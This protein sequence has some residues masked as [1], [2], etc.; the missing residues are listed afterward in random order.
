[1]LAM[2][3]LLAGASTALIFGLLHRSL[4]NAWVKYQESLSNEAESRLADMF[5]FVDLSQ[6]WPLLVALAFV[7]GLLGW[8]LLDSVAFS[9][10]VSVLVL[11]VPRLLLA[12][13]HAARKY[14]LDRQLPDALRILAAALSSGSSLSTALNVMAKDLNPPLS[15]ELSLILREQR[16]GIPL[17]SAL[18][19]F[20]LRIRSES[21]AQA[22]T[23]LRVG[24]ES[25]G[26]LALLLDKLSLN[27]SEQ[28]YMGLKV[29][30]LTT[31]G[32]MQAWVIGVLPLILLGV[33]CALDPNAMQLAMSNVIGQV[34]LV[35]IAVL[36][37]VGLLWL[38]AIL[39]TVCN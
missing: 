15:Q 14:T 9:M 22:T 13:A 30:M 11:T 20:R 10:S 37:L 5:V 33:L 35:I 32:K 3:L 2:G 21:V 6:L 38:R 18:E 12:R 16:V 4:T 27:L 34:V 39:R 36:E 25:G 26:S 24:A 17:Q 7:M 8:L 31:Q 23:L 19:N 28:Q 1:M 29:E